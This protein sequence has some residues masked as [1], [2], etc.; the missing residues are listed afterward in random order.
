MIKLTTVGHITKF[1]C[2]TGTSS[3]IS[4]KAIITSAFKTS[5]CIVT[6]CIGITA[7]RIF[8]T[9]INMYRIYHVYEEYK[10]RYTP[11]DGLPE[12]IAEGKQSSGV[13]RVYTPSRRGIS[14]LYNI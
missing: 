10:R 9:L 11:L 2:L 13:Y 4:F 6:S 14:G 7:M 3:S 5:Y 12:A 1:D 8:F